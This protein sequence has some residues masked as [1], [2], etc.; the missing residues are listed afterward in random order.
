MELHNLVW[1]EENLVT[2]LWWGKQPPAE[3]E[4][5]PAY[6]DINEGYEQKEKNMSSLVTEP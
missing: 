2:E 5:Y 4:E 6:W 3:R 1:Y